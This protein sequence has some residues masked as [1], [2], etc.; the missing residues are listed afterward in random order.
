[1]FVRMQNMA[2][3]P[4]RRARRSRAEWTAEVVRW[5]K[6]GLG[7]A[8]YAAT[9]EL[10]RSSLLWWSSQVGASAV[11]RTAKRVSASSTAFVPLRVREDKSDGEGVASGRG[12]IEV[13]LSNGRCVRVTGAV[14]TAELVR[15]LNAVEGTG[16][17]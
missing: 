2:T 4:E 16:R 3:K 10:K 17:C 5:R 14:D 11:D 8:E 6:S 13:I 12:S 7:S 9:R 15:V 1:M